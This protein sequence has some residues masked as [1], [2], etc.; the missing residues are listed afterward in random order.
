MQ[1]PI[2]LLVPAFPCVGPQSSPAHPSFKLVEAFNLSL[3]ERVGFEPTKLSFA[4]FQDRC[5]QP[6]GH[7]SRCGRM[8]W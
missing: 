3:A 8:Q 4:C 7:L 6:L 2:E 5:L 1:A